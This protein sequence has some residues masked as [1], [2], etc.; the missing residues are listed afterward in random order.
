[1]SPLRSMGT[2]AS[3]LFSTKLSCLEFLIVA[4]LCTRLGFSVRDFK[5]GVLIRLGEPF[6]TQSDGLKSKSVSG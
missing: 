1:M 4:H 6:I 3:V 5:F 2:T